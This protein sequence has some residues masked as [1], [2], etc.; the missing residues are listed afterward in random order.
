MPSARATSTAVSL[1]SLTRRTA[2]ILNSREN[3]RRVSAMVHLSAQLTRY[4]NSGPAGLAKNRQNISQLPEV[5]PV[6]KRHTPDQIAAAL[7]QAEAGT[8]IAEIVRKLGV[9]E[10]TFY[11]WKRRFGGL[12]TPEIRELRQLRE[13]NAKLKGIVADLSLDRKMLQ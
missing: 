9:H 7:R 3:F 1:P 4:P 11:V 10:N 2:S 5:L 8:P 12:G 13:E 6:R